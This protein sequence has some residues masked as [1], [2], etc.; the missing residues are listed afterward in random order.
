MSVM[1]TGMLAIRRHLR[2]HLKEELKHKD[3]FQAFYYWYNL[4]KVFNEKRRNIS[5][6]FRKYIKDHSLCNIC[7][8]E[9]SDRITFLYC[10]HM[11]CSKC[12][13][14]WFEQSKRFNVQYVEKYSW[15]EHICDKDLYY[16]HFIHCF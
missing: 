16:C 10:K 3:Y 15:R 9:P 8:E 11:F 7:L 14:E 12:I 2:R 13:T 5:P 1:A 6:S 4:K